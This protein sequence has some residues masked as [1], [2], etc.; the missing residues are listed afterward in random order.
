MPPYFT[1][2]RHTSPEYWLRNNPDHTA[3]AD[4]YILTGYY[5]SH[6]NS[7]THW[8]KANSHRH[9][10][11]LIS[12]CK[13][14][15]SRNKQVRSYNST[16]IGNESSPVIGPHGYS[17]ELIKPY[18]NATMLMLEEEHDE[19]ALIKLHVTF[20]PGSVSKMAAEAVHGPVGEQ[21][22]WPSTTIDFDMET[23]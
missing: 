10:F 13:A 3:A 4:V 22:D 8:F 11:G 20:P 15:S 5:N 6:G 1:G 12:G 17:Y 16:V 18:V 14:K 7:G 23:V 21:D 19:T 9:Y 2:Y